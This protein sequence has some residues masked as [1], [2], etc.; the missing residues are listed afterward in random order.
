[1]RQAALIISIIGA[2][3][4]LTS[5]YYEENGFYGAHVYGYPWITLI[6][7]S[8]GLCGGILIFMKTKIGTWLCVFV[9]VSGIFTAFELWE[10]AGSF[11]LMSGLLGFLWRQQQNHTSSANL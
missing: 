4:G 10:G 5:A 1:M 11:F 2:A 3:L 9:A 7:S 6:V 8:L